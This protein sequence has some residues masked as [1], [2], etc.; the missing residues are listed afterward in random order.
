MPLPSNTIPVAK[1]IYQVRIP[2]PHGSESVN[3]YLFK[4]EEGW[5]IL[6]TGLNTPNAQI[7]W[8]EIFKT[9]EVDQVRQIFLTHSDP[10]HYGLAGWLQ[11]HFQKK[12]DDSVTP[13]LMSRR[14]TELVRQLWGA[15]EKWKKA[16]LNFWRSCGVPVDLALSL[17]AST[18]NIRLRILPH[19]NV[20]KS[21]EEG[22]RV[23][24]GDREFEVFQMAGHSDGQLLFYDEMD[25]LLLVG[26]HILK[27]RF[28]HISQWPHGEPDPLGRYLFSLDRLEKMNVRL[29]LPSHGPLIGDLAGRIEEVKQHHVLRLEQ[30]ITAVK[31]QATVFEASQ[32]LFDL[33]SLAIQEKRYAIAETLAHLEFLVLRQRL[34]REDGRPWTYSPMEGKRNRA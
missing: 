28:T 30:T 31:P 13:V 21:I 20:V 27:E 29:T 1:Y 17:I 12:D 3:C 18:G 19:P 8:R 6:D 32:Q 10:E 24:L 11:K 14:E 9:L 25:R 34:Q 16:L 5:D 2:I 4:G 33:D 22:Q 15:E 26:D 7:V 23:R